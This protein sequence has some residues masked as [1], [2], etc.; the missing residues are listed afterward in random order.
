VKANY[1]LI[2]PREGSPFETVF[3]MFGGIYFWFDKIIGVAYNEIL[4]QIHFWIF[5]IGVNFM[6]FSNAFF[7]GVARADCERFV[8]RLLVL[9]MPIVIRTISTGVEYR[10]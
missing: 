1:R 5:F 3:S 4:G 8:D 7:L 2:R 9:L 6:F 10:T